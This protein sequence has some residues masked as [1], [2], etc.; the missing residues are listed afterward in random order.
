MDRFHSLVEFIGEMGLYAAE[1]QKKIQV[2]Y[3]DDGSVLTETDTYINKQVKKRI[4]T[5]F[6]E[7]GI[8]TEEQITAF[9][10]SRE[11]TFIL[12]PIDGTDSY[13]Q[14]MPSWCISVGIL[15]RNRLPVAAIVLAPRWGLGGKDSLLL[16]LDFEGRMKLNGE[17]F[18]P[19]G[20]GDDIEQLAM[21]SHVQHYI[22]LKTY[23]GK[24]RSFGSN[25]LHMIAPLVHPRI[26]GSISIP[27]Y[28]WDVAGAH[29]LLR[30]A[31][32]PVTYRNGEEFTY[33]DELLVE[34]R[35]FQGILLS[36]NP[37]AVAQMRNLFA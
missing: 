29:A 30:A 14:G 11:Y 5:L 10:E 33:T 32:W 36:G 31:G 24:I 21:G 16:T 9:D 2:T 17:P 8:I 23:R 25:I 3:K 19:S 15:D 20:P 22:D 12:D 1:N 28:V 26:Q 34:R 6:P 35:T 7:A 18:T 13:S 37:E 27:C 4:E